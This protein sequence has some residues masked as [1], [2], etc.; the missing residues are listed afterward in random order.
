MIVYYHILFLVNKM[1]GN[2]IT[3]SILFFVN[4]FRK[5]V[6]SLRP[7]IKC[8]K[9]RLKSLSSLPGNPTKR[10]ILRDPTFVFT[11][12][13]LT[14][15]QNLG[16]TNLSEA[17]VQREQFSTVTLPVRMN[18]TLNVA[19]LNGVQSRV[20]GCGEQFRNGANIKVTDRNLNMDDTTP[21]ELASYFDQ[22]L[23]IPK[24]MSQI[25]EMMYT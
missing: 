15:N 4:H 18:P 8:T 11:G 12:T 20:R 9:A 6:V 19:E 22:L 10:Q 1:F 24:P 5:K 13:L 3:N 14:E 2:L 23:H 21:E 25:A 7:R 17:K 16:N